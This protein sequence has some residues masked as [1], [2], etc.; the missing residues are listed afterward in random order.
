MFGIFYDE[1]VCEQVVDCIIDVIV[2][3]LKVVV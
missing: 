2:F 3:L 1:D